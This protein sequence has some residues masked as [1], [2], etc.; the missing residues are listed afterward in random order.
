MHPR[1]NIR[2]FWAD[3]AAIVAL[4]IATPFV[5]LLTPLLDVSLYPLP[6]ILVAY[7]GYKT[8]RW[9]GLAAGALATL[10]WTLYAVAGG[11]PF[12]WSGLLWGGDRLELAP[13][14]ELPYIT[15]DAFGIQHV[16]L[17]C[18]VGFVS[19]WLFDR[20]DGA[21]SAHGL[22]LEALIDEQP[23]R[24]VLVAAVDRLRLWLGPR[25]VGS[26]EEG[27]R[28]RRLAIG[29]IAPGFLVALVLLNVTFVVDREPFEVRVPPLLLPS[30]LVLVLAF[31]AGS[32]LAIL[33]AVVVWAGSIALLVFAID[34]PPPFEGSWPLFSIHAIA[35]VVGLSILAWWVGKVGEVLRDDERRQ[36]VQAWFQR[37]T[38]AAA[39]PATPSMLLLP[40]IVVL[41]IGVQADLGPVLVRYR[42]Y[43]LLF[44]ALCLWAQA[45]D[46]VSVS[47]RAFWCLLPFTLIGWDQTTGWQ[48]GAPER[49]GFFSAELDAV[50]LVL[51]A[52]AP[53]VAGRLDLGRRSVCRALAYGF[54]VVWAVS[55]LYLRSG[56]AEATFV[57]DVSLLQ[58]RADPDLPA[59]LVPLPL[60]SWIVQ[61]AFFALVARALHAAATRPWLR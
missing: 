27:A 46:S 2:H 56:V 9:S 11:R 8:G 45:R 22:G 32:R 39:S 60:V 59:H 52:A 41:A 30:V 42:P 24:S 20:L 5:W 14:E 54:L 53:L 44:L 55:D 35:Q 19:G 38:P 58:P 40:A 29:L 18:L 17:A 49:L 7:L 6:Y 61:V 47:N 51:L 16:V 34:L 57:L 37:F 15:V 4:A 23:R 1:T 25:A 43:G 31:L 50:M 12:F 26:S 33:T 10:P 13:F 28:R 21:L 36:R 48:R 3:Y